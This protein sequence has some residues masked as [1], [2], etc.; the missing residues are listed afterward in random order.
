MAMM[1]SIMR[2]SGVELYRMGQRN[3]LAR[4]PIHWHLMGNAAGQYIKHSSI[5]ES[6]NRCVTIHGTSGVSRG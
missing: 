6:F 1:G 2:V 3:L 4:Y 5:H